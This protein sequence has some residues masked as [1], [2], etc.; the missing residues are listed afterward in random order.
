MS[1]PYQV[2]IPECLVDSL[3]PEQEILG[4]LAELAALGAHSEDELAGA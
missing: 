2:V 1:K 4:E 3:E